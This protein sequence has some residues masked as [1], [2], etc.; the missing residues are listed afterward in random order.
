MGGSRKGKVMAKLNSSPAVIAGRPLEANE[1]R[2]IS[3]R[4]IDGGYIVRT[5][6]CNESTGEYRT[7]E[8]FTK[9]PPKIGSLRSAEASGEDKAGS[10]GLADTMNYMAAKGQPGE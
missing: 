6:Y 8:E 3:T 7:R 4:K 1:S 9:S 5:S 10:L 2:S